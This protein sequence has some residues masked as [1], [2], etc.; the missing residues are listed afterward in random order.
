MPEDANGRPCPPMGTF[1]TRGYPPFRGWPGE[2]TA[3]CGYQPVARQ[4][5]QPAPKP[6]SQGSS[7][8]EK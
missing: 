4:I 8:K 6:P 2:Q 5:S 7:G 1:E 3:A